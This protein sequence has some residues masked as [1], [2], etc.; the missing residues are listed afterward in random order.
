MI[1]A[2]FE[3]VAPLDQADALRGQPLELDRLDLGAVLLEL[4]LALRLLVGV[5][6]A[7]DALGLA[8]EQIDEGPEQIGGI[9]LEAGAGE[10]GFERF[11]DCAE[12]ALD[13]FVPG[14]GRGSGSSWPGR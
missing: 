4:A 10:Q 12:M 9:V 1:A 8:V 14:I 6:L 13:G 3:G 5:E 7:L 2:E 11:G